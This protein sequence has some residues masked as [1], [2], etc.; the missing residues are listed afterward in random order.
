MTISNGD[1]VKLTSSFTLEDGTIMQNIYHWRAAVAS[2]YGNPTITAAIQTWIEDALDNF[3]GGCSDTVAANL[4]SVDQ[5]E[6]VEEEGLWKVVQNLGTFVPSFTP[7]SALDPMPNQ[8]CPC[9]VFKTPRPRTTGKKFVFPFTEGSYD[10]STLSASLVTVL[11]NYAADVLTN[12]TLAPLNDLIPGVPRSAYPVFYDFYLGVVTNI[13]GSQ[14]R[15]K[16]GV[17]A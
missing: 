3:E 17:G 13:C 11:T 12:I 2:V 10:G 4:H 15:R 14:R 6:W 5:V 8:V 16:P 7:A 9:V 1:I